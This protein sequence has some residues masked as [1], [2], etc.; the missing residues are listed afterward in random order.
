MPKLKLFLIS[1]L[2]GDLNQHEVELNPEIIYKYLR[3]LGRNF[4]EDPDEDEATNS[5]HSHHQATGDYPFVKMVRKKKAS[6]ISDRKY[7]ALLMDALRA[8]ADIHH[9]VEFQKRYARDTNNEPERC[10]NEPQKP[11][12]TT[13]KLFDERTM[14]KRAPALIAKQMENAKNDRIYRMVD[15]EY[16]LEKFITISVSLEMQKKYREDMKFYDLIML[17]ERGVLKS[18]PHNIFF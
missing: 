16:K 10:Q 11:K 3:K 4:V 18:L 15:S 7:A 9:I 6:T 1:K 5:V 2:V 8:Y 13:L 17:D 14:R 12:K